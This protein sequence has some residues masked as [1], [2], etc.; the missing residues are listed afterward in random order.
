[1]KEIIS[2][3]RM[4]E[5]GD[6]LI[7]AYAE[8][9]SQKTWHKMVMDWNF[10]NSDAFLDWLAD[11]PQTD[12][13]TVLIIYWK[14]APRYFK[15][16]KDK[17]HLLKEEAYSLKNF[18]RLEKIETNFATGFY[19]NQNFE[20]NPA[21]DG[22]FDWTSDYSDIE[23]VNEIPEIMFQKLTGKKIKMPVDFNEGFPPELYERLE[24]LAIN[25][26]VIWDEDDEYYD[27]EDEDE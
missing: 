3:E 8:D 19:E 2:V 6:E 4:D 24:K 13:A 23:T 26:N 14:S 10:D 20:Y 1:M 27:F 7:L 15:Q 21:N 12:K 25:Y 11:N 9:A 17:E 18:E 16:F 5:L 22:D